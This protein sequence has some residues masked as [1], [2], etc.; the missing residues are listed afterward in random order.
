[1]TKYNTTQLNTFDDLDKF[2]Q[3]RDWYAHLNRFSYVSKI[4]KIGQNVLDFG[5]GD[6]NLLESLYRN[7]HRC[8]K[9][10]GL[11][12]RKKIIES[13]QQQW[14][15]VKWAE[16]KNE[17]LVRGKFDYGN[18]WDLII[19]FEVI[20][21]I[22]KENADLFLQNILKHMNENTILLLS[23]PCYNGKDCAQNH[24][25]DG[26]VGEFTYSEMKQLLEKYFIIE[27]NYGTF[28]SIADYKD[29]LNDWQLKY[30]EASKEFFDT[31]MLATIM[32]PLI[33]EHSRNCLWVCKR[34]VRIF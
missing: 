10:L 34:N 6:A 33:P 24:M 17:D 32:A 7:K 28:A 9:Y 26:K 19:S 27:K 16:F 2:I 18:V 4:H 5:C 15:I 23:T 25:I 3:H 1:M 31:N 21:H 11:D 20:E 29:C 14:N 22:G 13:N 8:N 30:F 12:I